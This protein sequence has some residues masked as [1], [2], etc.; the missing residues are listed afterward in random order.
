MLR[1]RPPGSGAKKK[2]VRSGRAVKESDANR[3]SAAIRGPR[4][5][6]AYL[7]RRR[8]RKP[9]ATTP[10][11]SSG[12]VL[13]IS[14]AFTGAANT[15]AVVAKAA[16]RRRVFRG[17]K[18]EGSAVASSWRANSSSLLPTGKNEIDLLTSCALLHV[19]GEWPEVL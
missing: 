3:R 15:D 2:P 8:A 5:S 16:R 6:R 4:S 1:S 17:E 7:R 10:T 19:S 14:G 9:S 18:V 11:A 13:E 12:R